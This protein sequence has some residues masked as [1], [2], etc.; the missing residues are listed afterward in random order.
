M[1]CAYIAIAAA[2]LQTSIRKSLLLQQQ[3]PCLVAILLVPTLAFGVI[4][5]DRGRQ[6]YPAKLNAGA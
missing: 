6:C 3:P 5:G 4:Q 2:Y 1:S